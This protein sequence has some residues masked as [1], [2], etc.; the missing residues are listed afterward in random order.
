MTIATATTSFPASQWYYLIGLLVFYCVCVSLLFAFGKATGT[1]SMVKFPFLQI[2]DSLRRLTGFPGWAMG[3]VL[4]GLLFLLIAVIGFYWDVAWHI[5][6]GRDKNVF[7][8]PHVMILVGLW[9][10]SFAG[11]VTAVMA[12]IE[13]VRIPKAAML[14]GLLG[15]VAATAF[16]IDNLWH[17]AYGLDITLWSPS[18]LQLVTGGGFG[19]LGVLLLLA[20]AM[21]RAR[22]T[23]LGRGIVVLAFGAALVGMSVF[24]GEFDYGV[25]QFQLV[26]LPILL[27]AAA[28][29]TLVLA[30]IALGPGGA[31]KAVFVYLV[32]RGVIALVV[33]GALDHSFP[34]FPLY[35][36]A[37]VAV[38]GAAALV[39]TASRLRF[40]LVAGA[41]VGTLG[42]AGELAFVGLS[43]YGPLSAS[44][45][46][47]TILLA[48]P[49]AFA[50]AVLGA[51]LARVFSPGDRRVP[52]AAAALACVVLV[53]A[54]LI[55][56]ARNV[57]H[58][59]AVI[60]LDRSQGQAHVE[61]ALQPAAAARRAAA[62]G[63]LSWQGGGRVRTTFHEI[64][65]GHYVSSGAVPVYGTWKS[66]VVLYRGDEVMAAPIYLPADPAIKATAVPAVSRRSVDFVRNTK[67][68][69]REAKPG[70]PLPATLAY[71]VWGAS[72]VLWVAFLAF[73]T[74][75]TGRREPE[76]P[77]RAA[78]NEPRPLPAGA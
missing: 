25:P 7:T 66:M 53:A 37:A 29:F 20:E 17:K 65:P 6:L 32:L 73:T 57:G 5:D 34:R 13:R 56:L 22:P 31:V 42:L 74:W 40:A 68:L 27:V 69:L 49:A 61:V 19:T 62:F 36:F 21:P 77:S 55:P 59:H 52:G 64:R 8:P 9:G 12:S 46:P 30:R 71:A 3:G 54:L 50:A 23:L 41:L 14:L 24:L 63:V 51:G 75:Q 72:T 48:V 78:G 44:L 60:R 2:S 11:V 39:G 38:E 45:L 33:A 43:G 58:V 26:Y 67:V 18:H 15:V 10:I 28:G 1:P 76:R 16:P 4:T 70:P 35:L 47:R